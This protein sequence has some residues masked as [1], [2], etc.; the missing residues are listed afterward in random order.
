MSNTRAG[1]SDR[2]LH[3]YDIPRAGACW[4]ASSRPNERTTRL[5]PRARARPLCVVDL[6]WDTSSSSLEQGSTFA[7]RSNLS[8]CVGSEEDVS[9]ASWDPSTVEA[10]K[11]E[12]SNTRCERGVL[13]YGRFVAICPSRVVE[14]GRVLRPTTPTGP[15]RV[16]VPFECSTSS[17]SCSLP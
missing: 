15:S 12:E 9:A 1:C 17:C 7:C 13:R 8:L 5:Q 10:L 3:G 6:K 2:I 14:V 11:D 16:S 4:H